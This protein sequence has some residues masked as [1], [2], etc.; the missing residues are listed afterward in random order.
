MQTKKQNVKVVV[1]KCCGGSSVGALDLGEDGDFGGDAI[2]SFLDTL[3]I[4]V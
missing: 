3:G 4:T 2:Q 1:S